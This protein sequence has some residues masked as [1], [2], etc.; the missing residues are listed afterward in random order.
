MRLPGAAD[1]PARLRLPAL[2]D[3]VRAVAPPALVRSWGSTCPRD[4]VA[5]G[6][7]PHGEVGLS[8]LIVDGVNIAVGI[9]ECA[10]TLFEAQAQQRMPR[11]AVNGTTP[12]VITHHQAMALPRPSHY[13]V[14]N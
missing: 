2:P 11:I 7:M 8:R 5:A 9:A 6:L 12:P 13:R 3:C 4:E 10:I 1:R 14:A